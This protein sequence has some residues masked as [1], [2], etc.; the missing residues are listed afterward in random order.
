M[1]HFLKEI[2]YQL[3]KKKLENPSRPININKISM[4]SDSKP[5]LQHLYAVPYSKSLSTKHLHCGPYSPRNWHSKRQSRWFRPPDMKGTVLSG[6]VCMSTWEWVSASIVT[7]AG[8]NTMTIVGINYWTFYCDV[9]T[10][11]TLFYYYTHQA[12]EKGNIIPIL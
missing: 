7:L 12:Q 6:T 4:E 10:L 2:N 3:S 1:D 5:H 9:G 8:M 11:Y